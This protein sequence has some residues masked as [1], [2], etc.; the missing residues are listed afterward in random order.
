MS[1]KR[2][3]YAWEWR[4]AATPSALWP[5]VS[6]TN[7]FNRDAGVPH[8]E[9]SAAVTPGTRRLK[10]R[11]YGVPIEWDEEPF[12]WV[13]PRSFGVV[14]KYATGPVVEMRVRTQLRADGAEHS[15]LRYEVDI[16][17]RNI[18]GYAAIP[19]EIGFVSARRFRAV[20][21][22]YAQ[23]AKAA[24]SNIIERVDFLSAPARLATGARDRM[25]RGQ[26]ALA[27]LFAR[28]LIDALFDVVRR[29]HDSSAARIRP[30]VLADLW[31]VP[32]RS[33]VD[34]CL[35]AT[36]AGIL[37]L[38]WDVLCPMCRGPKQSRASLDGISQPVHCESCN[39][40][41]YAN[42]EQQV[43]LTFRPNAA[44]RHID[45]HPFC[46]GG[47]QVTPHIVAQQV[48]PAHDRRT[49][50]VELEAGGYRTRVGGVPG[51]RL[52]RAEGAGAQEITLSND[53]DEPRLVM[54]ERLAWSDQ[55]LIAA[56]VIALQE[57]RDLFSSEALRPGEAISVGNMAILFTD[58]RDSTKLYRSIGDAPAFGRVQDHFDILRE[59]MRAEEGA[60]VKTI[61]DAVM[62]AFR[63]PAAAIRTIM[64]A[65]E[66]LAGLPEGVQPTNLKAGVH[67]GPC[68][69]VTLNERLD[70]FGSTVNIA[71]RLNGFSDG[72]DIIISDAVAL[73]PEVQS[74]L[75]EPHLETSGFQAQLK[76]YEDAPLSLVRVRSSQKG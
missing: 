22:R 58:L 65:R 17:P 20:F 35:H 16:L 41:Y 28:E 57:F 52:F 10:L 5:L 8:V 62:A 76:G 42:F 39:I 31:Q 74:L 2:F 47:P 19:F 33:V 29:G 45:I 73:D 56:E 46:I 43:E 70:Y 55:A 60:L 51:A 71:A 63:R 69:A 12:E 53:S 59:A 18:L 34:L 54:V 44:I 24:P 14:R 38:Q 4:L 37:D 26:Q 64:R 72:G 50:E 27:K 21:E 25:E 48:V 9:E 23:E 15:I 49:V 7:R 1:R 36:R 11:R 32:R 6:D 40:D 66:L 67:F 61:G 68:I 13:R 3:H 75:H 30:Y